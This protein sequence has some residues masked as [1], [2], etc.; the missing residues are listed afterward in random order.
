[1]IHS[2]TYVLCSNLLC[3]EAGNIKKNLSKCSE[4]RK[5]LC[6]LTL[7]ILNKF[8]CLNGL[9][10]DDKS[11]KHIHP[12]KKHLS[13]PYIS[14]CMHGINCRNHNC[15]FLHPNEHGSWLVRV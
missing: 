3:R 10:C 15:L 2:V 7:E 6:N 14:P 5:S 9:M 1:M 8:Y 13:P 4:C 11:C 12:T